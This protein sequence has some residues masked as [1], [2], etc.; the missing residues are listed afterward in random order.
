MD[1]AGKIVSSAFSNLD[2]T[3]LEKLVVR[4]SFDL[5]L[6]S[7]FVKALRKNVNLFEG[8]DL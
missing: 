3:R 6:L 7:D 8:L 2:Q 5:L 4:M 1:A